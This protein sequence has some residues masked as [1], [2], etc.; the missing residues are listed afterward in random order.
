MK[1]RNTQKTAT[2]EKIEL[3]PYGVVNG[4][5]VTKPKHGGDSY[6]GGKSRAGGITQ[7]GNMDSAQAA[8]QV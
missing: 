8:G 6:S 7:P 4:E 5:F 2:R 3:E 1:I